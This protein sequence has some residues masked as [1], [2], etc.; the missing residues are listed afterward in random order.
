M[1]LD[2]INHDRVYW[3]KKPIIS[4]EYGLNFMKYVDNDL[5]QMIDRM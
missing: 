5:E 1:N 3:R 2:L 4:D